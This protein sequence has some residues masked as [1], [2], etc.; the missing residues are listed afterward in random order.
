MAGGKEDRSKLDYFIKS[1]FKSEL[2]KTP[3]KQIT[4]AGKY[5]P[6]SPGLRPSLLGHEKPG[7]RRKLH[8][9]HYNSNNLA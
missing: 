9:L 8:H 2:N 4:I 7:N 6:Q 1:G 3:G 5:T